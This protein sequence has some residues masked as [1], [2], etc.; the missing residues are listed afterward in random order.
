MSTKRELKSEILKKSDKMIDSH[1]EFLDMDTDEEDFGHQESPDADEELVPSEP[2][3][4]IFSEK[5]LVALINYVKDL[6]IHSQ[7]GISWN[8]HSDKIIQEY[9]KNPSYTVLTTFYDKS[10]LNAMLDIPIYASKGFTY[11][12]RSSWQIYTPDNF[13]KTVSFGSISNNIKNNTLKFM[14]SIYAPIMLHNEDYASFLRCDMFSNLHEFIIRLMEEIYKSINRTILYVPKEHLL[15]TFLKSSDTDNYFLLG[16]NQ[17]TI[18]SEEHEKKRKLIGRLEKI[19]WFWIRQIHRATMTSRKREIN[20]IQDEVDYWNAKHSDLNHLYAQFRNTE[21]QLIIHILKNLYSPSASK[22]QELTVYIDIGLAEAQSNLMYLNIL[23]HFCKNLNIL[24]DV[25]NSITEALLLILFIW[26]ES[27]FYSTKSNMEIL[28]QALSSQIIEQCKKH[29]KLDIVLGNNP[30]MGI[31]ML[32][33]CIFCCNIYKT[34]YEDIMINVISY[35]NPDKKWDINQQEVFSKIDIFKQ[36]CC[37]VIEISK[38]L[39]VFERDTKIGLIGGPNGSEFEAYLREIES[40]FY[41]SLNE[42]IMAHDI[43]FDVTRPIWFLKIKQFRYTILQL[44]NMVINLI[45]DI[46]KTIRNI[47]EGIETIYALQKFK[48]RENLRELLQKKQIQIWKIFSNEIEYCYINAINQ[49]K[50]EISVNINLLCILQ[51]LKKQHSIITNAVDWMGEC[52]FEK[53]VLQQYEHVLDVIDKR[54]K[55]FNSYSINKTQ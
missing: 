22:L 54:S 11:F 6:T 16:T 23:L 46:F 34:I 47:E 28:C 30:E 38:I 12:L 42:I 3:K 5:D 18:V 29:I 37:D 19:V 50:K 25:E 15:Q 17:T 52:D 1:R 8:K 35:I 14:E 7:N 9:F 48:R 4:P 40:L 26:T 53:C 10:E 51:Y 32:T 27:P 2:E 41:E 21:V 49:S 39:T 43:I 33:K 55:M 45:N 44:E 31:Q 13:L 36:R 24:E 20:N